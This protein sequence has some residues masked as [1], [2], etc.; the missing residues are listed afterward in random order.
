MSNDWDVS[1]YYNS[2]FRPEFMRYSRFCNRIAIS[3][4]YREVIKLPF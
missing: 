1:D 3:P 4:Q 2:A